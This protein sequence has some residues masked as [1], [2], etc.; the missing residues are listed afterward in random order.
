MHFSLNSQCWESRMTELLPKCDKSSLSHHRSMH[1]QTL[2][3]LF[4][5]YYVL[6]CRNQD[7]TMLRYVILQSFAKFGIIIMRK[8][9]KFICSSL[10]RILGLGG[11]RQQWSRLGGVLFSLEKAK[12]SRFCKLENFQKMLKKQWKF[13]SFLKIYM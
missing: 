7:S 4:V 5:T 2:V 12:I 3:N 6:T 9:W 13:Y 1:R 10:Y 11:S 8:V